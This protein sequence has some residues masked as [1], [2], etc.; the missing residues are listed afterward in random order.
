[1]PFNWDANSRSVMSCRY[2]LPN[3][4]ELIFNNISFFKDLLKRDRLFIIHY[5]NIQSIGIEL[6][7]VNG[8]LSNTIM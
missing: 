3:Y 7:K 6:F 1:M 2:E 8:N 4:Y 5:S